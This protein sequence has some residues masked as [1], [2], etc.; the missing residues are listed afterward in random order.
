MQNLG[1]ERHKTQR[2]CVHDQMEGYILI[3]R[4]RKNADNIQR[5]TKIQNQ[6]DDNVSSLKMY[7]K[8]V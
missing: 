3:K 5:K 4:C 8:R 2:I 1:K 6:N 7:R